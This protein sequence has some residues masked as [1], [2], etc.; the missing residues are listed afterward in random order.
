[1]SILKND[2]RFGVLLAGACA[3]EKGVMGSFWVG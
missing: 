1:M 3:W 2:L